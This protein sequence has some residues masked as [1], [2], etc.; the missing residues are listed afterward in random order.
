MPPAGYSY[1]YSQAYADPQQ[2]CTPQTR[3]SCC[4]E[5]MTCH[6]ASQGRT[7]IL[8]VYA[9]D[10]TGMGK[11]TRSRRATQRTLQGIQDMTFLLLLRSRRW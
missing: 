7:I 2:W 1:D 5:A 9:G 11:P 8:Q 3:C 4:P 10:D 6:E